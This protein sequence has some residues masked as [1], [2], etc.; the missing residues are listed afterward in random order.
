MIP[1]EDIKKLVRNVSIKTD[2]KVD[3][4]VLNSLFDEL[5]KSK[6][7]DS[8]V[9]K[10][11]IWRMIMISRITK[12]AAVA[13]I[14]VAA[15]LSVNIFIKSTPAAFG[16]E[17]VIDAY[18]NIR[19]LHVKQFRA[20]QQQP[21]EFWIKSDEQ[22]RAVKARY[23]LPETEDGVKLITWKPEG[24]ELWFKS[25]G[26]LA[27]I[28]TKRIEGWM[29]SILEQCQPKLVMQKL[30]DDQKAGK[31]KVDIQK[32][33]ERQK[34]AVIV[35]TYKAE[36]KKEIYYID[37]GTDLITRIESYSVKDNKEVPRSTT[38]FCDYNVPIDEKMFSLRDEVPKDVK[39]ADRLNQLTGIPQG[40]MSDEQAAEET[41][42]QYLQAL[43][44]KDYKKAGL[45]CGGVLEEYAKEDFGWC[46][47]NSIISI[48][49]AIPEPDWDEHGFKVP[50]ELEITTKDGRKIT[51]KD[52]QYVR[53]G[54]DEMHP[55][56][57]NIT[58][59]GLE[60]GILQTQILPDNERYERMTPKEAAE[61]F[62][63]ACAEKDWDEFLKFWPLPEDDKQ[64]EQT[65]E[66]LGGL[67][68]ISI[69]EPF[70][71]DKYG[72]YPGW[73]VPYEIKFPPMGINL[74]LSNAN[75]ARRF[76]VTGICD[77]KMRPIGD[78]GEMDWS[79]EPNVLPDNEIYAG[80]SPDEAAAAFAEALSKQDW[81]EMRK[82]L[83]ASFIEEMKAEF[84]GAIFEVIGKALW[85]DEQSAY[86]V[87]CRWSGQ[88]K[89]WNLAIR[90]DNPANR[91][92]FDGGI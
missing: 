25:K 22:G 80:M 37:Q 33:Q 86:F 42:R 68:I 12:L 26:G 82:F 90:N 7:A 4:A 24:T 58:S 52:Y 53:P 63:K 43:I 18:N 62:F 23:Y 38:E 51:C 57:W 89:K 50:F 55:D 16:I 71:S 92:M 3:E 56:R 78:I 32:P 2:P 91:Y 29:Q 66:Y 73:F 19:F 48:G 39:I 30:L 34:P 28:Q 8:V 67:E 9:S 47:V 72:E 1:A 13:V 75:S 88:V 76:V 35:A 70:K 41:I 83:P 85:S 61:A 59:G 77:S 20:N 15:V 11:G 87:K 5:D 84:E 45:I 36:P 81:N 64:T 54:D 60:A 27:L 10:P 17:Q 44:D 21:N 65:K 6:K 40:E 79:N 31:A 69:G 46:N 74:R 49:P 14:A